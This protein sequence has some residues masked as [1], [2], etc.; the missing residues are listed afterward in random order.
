MEGKLKK[1]ESSK[2]SFLE[3]ECLKC[4]NKQIIFGR[5]STK[6]DCIKCGENLAIPRGGKAFINAK[7]LKQI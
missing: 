4:K 5:A 6:V 1:V 3:V 2:K 7:I